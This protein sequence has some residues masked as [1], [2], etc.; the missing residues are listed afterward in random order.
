MDSG[1][2]VR[3]ALRREVQKAAKVDV[4]FQA[5]QV[6]EARARLNTRDLVRIAMRVHQE[7]YKGDDFQAADFREM[8][9]LVPAEDLVGLGLSTPPRKAMLAPRYAP[10][11][12][13]A[14]EWAGT[15]LGGSGRYTPAEGEASD[16][17]ARREAA[18]LDG[19][20]RLSREIDKLLIQSGVTVAQ[21]LA[22]H[23]DLK[24]DV[25]LFLSGARVIS[26]AAPR[27]DGTVEVKLELPLR[28]LWEILR[29]NMRLEEVEPP[30]AGSGPAGGE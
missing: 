20:E 2:A 10:I 3:D 29:R 12:Y 15:A 13:N 6:A 23:Q 27:A 8:A 19:I 18:R 28:R 30:P 4:R 17:A 16:E 24:E 1:E 7:E 21:Y 22:Y 5:D 9:L 11:E 25:A 26:A 14:P